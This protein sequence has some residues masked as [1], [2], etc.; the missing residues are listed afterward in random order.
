M[1]WKTWYQEHCCSAEEAVRRIQSGDRV[2]VA[3]A[4]GEPSYILDAMV[5]NA[6][7]YENVEIVHMVAMGK[8]EYC[9]PT[10]P[11]HRAPVWHCFLYGRQSNHRHGR[12]NQRNV[13]SFH[14]L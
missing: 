3:H 8:A 10:H 11:S 12:P 9:I 14:C 2:V 1:D 7:Q 5:A 4:T 6:D 13:A